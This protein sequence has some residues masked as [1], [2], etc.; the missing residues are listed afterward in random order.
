MR[1]TLLLWLAVI[2][3]LPG[4]GLAPAAEDKL[5]IYTAYEE[6]ELKM[7]KEAVDDFFSTGPSTISGAAG[8]RTD[9]RALGRRG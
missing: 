1:R 2:L 4:A 7:T 9:H 6:N 3:V 5:V 8:R